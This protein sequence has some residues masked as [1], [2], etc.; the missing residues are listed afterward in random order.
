MVRPVVHSVKHYVQ[1]PI[2]QIG[3]G[4]SVNLNVVDAL[5]RSAVNISREV[6]EGSIIKAIYFEMWL[7]MKSECPT[8]RRSLSLRELI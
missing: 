4:T 2:T 1:F 5:E 6:A 8:C 7:Q 3:M